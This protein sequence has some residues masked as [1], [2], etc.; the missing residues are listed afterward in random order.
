MKGALEI[1]TDMLHQ[2]YDVAPITAK[3]EIATIS[4]MSSVTQTIAGMMAY[5]ADLISC[6]ALVQAEKKLDLLEHK[7]FLQTMTACLPSDYTKS[8]FIDIQNSNSD[9]TL[10]VLFKSVTKTLMLLDQGTYQVQKNSD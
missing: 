8:F 5:R 7:L 10:E 6:R 2:T 9:F 4:R 1:A 3:Q